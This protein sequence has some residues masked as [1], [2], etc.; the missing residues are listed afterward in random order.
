MTSYQVWSDTRHLPNI[1]M[2]K[3]YVLRLDGCSQL[4]CCH[5]PVSCHHPAITLSN[6]HHLLMKLNRK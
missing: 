6:K 5:H 1:H 3:S 2:H 4:I